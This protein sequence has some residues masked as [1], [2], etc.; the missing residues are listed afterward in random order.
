MLKN[1]VYLNLWLWFQIYQDAFERKFLEASDRLYRAEGQRLMEERDVSWN[2]S[3]T[4]TKLPPLLS[5]H[6]H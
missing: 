4:C 6:L 2:Y 5:V 3:H 1:F